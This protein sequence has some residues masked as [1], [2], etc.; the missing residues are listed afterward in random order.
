MEVTRAKLTWIGNNLKETK[1]H[2]VDNFVM[3][4]TFDRFIGTMKLYIHFAGD[5]FLKQPI[6]EPRLVFVMLRFIY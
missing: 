3:G 6:F 1:S 2:S 4:E 5:D